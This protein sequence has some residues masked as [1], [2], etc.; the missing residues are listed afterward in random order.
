M[1]LIRADGGREIGSGHIMR[2]LSV[3]GALQEQ[4][5]EVLFVLADDAAAGLLTARGQQFRILH[6]D[7]RKPEE[8]LSVCIPI[9][10]A[11]RP[12]LFLADSYFVTAEYLAQVG[13]YTKTA[14]IDDMCAFPCPVD[15]LINYNIYGEMLPYRERAL[16]RNRAFLLG[17]AY[18]PL[19][20]EF[21]N[22]DYSVKENAAHVLITTGGGD[23]YNLAGQILQ[24]ALSDTGCR[25]LCYHAVSGSFNSNLPELRA[26]AEHHGNVRI[27]ENVRNMA[28]LMQQCDI[29]VTAGGS[30]MYELCAVG[31]PIVCFSFADNQERLVETFIEKRLVCYGGNYLKEKEEL[32]KRI[33]EHVRLL[34][35]SKALR[36]EYSHREKTLVDGKGTERLAKALIELAQEN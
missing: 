2:C 25:E 8:E 36:E 5:K 31:V 27:Y 13:R 24:L 3:A 11:Y 21:R 28:E 9:L 17:C 26:I 16:P 14:Y 15:I 30:T 22:V 1:I 29:A 7:Y 33:V 10:E 12:E 4:G 35:E 6:T 32:P 20:A 18:A 34:A 23:Q 19:R